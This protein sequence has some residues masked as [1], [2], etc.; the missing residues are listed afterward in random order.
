[1]PPL[2][3]VPP[4]T[5]A[6]SHARG[7]EPLLMVLVGGVV[8]CAEAVE[9][10]RNNTTA[11]DARSR[12]AA[13]RKIRTRA[14]RMGASAR[15]IQNHQWGVECPLPG[16]MWCV[17]NLSRHTRNGLRVHGPLLGV[18]TWRRNWE[19]TGIRNQV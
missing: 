11:I 19:I 17:L 10:P 12:T 4:P 7:P 5:G 14:S 1:M 3:T 9:L 18:Q 15:C 2:V 6:K 16:W 13:E 8:V